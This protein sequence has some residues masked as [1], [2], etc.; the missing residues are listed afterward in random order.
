[1]KL[2]LLQRRGFLAAR[3]ELVAALATSPPA[4][5][6]HLRVKHV[7]GTDEVWEM[8]FARDGRATFHLWLS[9]PIAVPRPR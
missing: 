6:P 8:T 7:K 4:F 5:P 3:D 9:S 2:S 1:M